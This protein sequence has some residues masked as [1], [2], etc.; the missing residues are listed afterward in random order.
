MIMYCCDENILRAKKRD[1]GDAHSHHSLGPA[2]CTSLCFL[3][4]ALLASVGIYSYYLPYCCVNIIICLCLCGCL[5]VYEIA[6]N[7]VIRLCVYVCNSNIMCVYTR[8]LFSLFIS[9]PFFAMLARSINVL[10][11]QSQL[12]E[13]CLP[14]QQCQ[15]LV[16]G[17]TLFLPFPDSRV[18][19]LSVS[20]RS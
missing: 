15:G 4:T 18:F 5:C 1:K 7:R 13:R 10:G 3:F 19:A 11:Y 2:C 16:Y 8:A 12:L 17:Y 9:S 6:H 20:R 14:R